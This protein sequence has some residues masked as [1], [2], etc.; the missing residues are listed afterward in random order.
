MIFDPRFSNYVDVFEGGYGYTRGV[1]RSEANSCMNYAIPYYN[2]ISRLDITR[3][4]FSLAGEPFDMERDFY[5]VDT[6]QWGSA[7]VN[8]TRATHNVQELQ[9]IHSHNVP[10]TLKRG[11][12]NQFFKKLKERRYEIN[13]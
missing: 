3:R 8:G 7:E 11:Q 6:D 2:A 1:W 13:R 10:V 12:Y 9:S 5:S 4:V